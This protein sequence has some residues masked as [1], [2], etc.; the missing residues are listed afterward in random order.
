MILPPHLEP[1]V[2]STIESPRMSPFDNSYTRKRQLRIREMSHSCNVQLL[3]VEFWE[4][5]CVFFAIHMMRCGFVTS[6]LFRVSMTGERLTRLRRNIIPTS[7][8]HAKIATALKKIYFLEDDKSP[9]WS[10][11]ISM[12]RYQRN[13]F[14]IV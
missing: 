14:G 2:R 6:R 5:H 10:T 13:F 8:W 11:N 4:Q 7:R 3:T 9:T 1:P 12:F